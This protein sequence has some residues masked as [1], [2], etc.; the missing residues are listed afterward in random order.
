LYNGV[1]GCVDEGTLKACKTR[2]YLCKIYQKKTLRHICS[3][4]ISSN[5]DQIARYC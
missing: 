5:G 2:N 1:S 3:E 4:N